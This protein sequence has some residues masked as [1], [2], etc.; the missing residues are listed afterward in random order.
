M[1]LMGTLCRKKHCTSQGC[2]CNANSNEPCMYGLEL[3]GANRLLRRILRLLRW[4]VRCVCIVHGQ[5]RSGPQETMN[6]QIRQRMAADRYG[7]LGGNERCS[8]M[9]RKSSAKLNVYSRMLKET[10]VIHEQKSIRIHGRGGQGVV[11]A[12]ELLAVAAFHDGEH[13]LAFPSFGSERMGA[14]VIAYCRISTSPI[15]THAPIGAPDVLIIQDATLLNSADTLLGLASDGFCFIN[16]LRSAGELAGD[17]RLPALPE[18]HLVSL[19]ATEIA[20]T[21]IGRAVPNVPLLGAYAVVCEDISIAALEHAIRDRFPPAIAEK[22][23]R[24]VEAGAEAAR[25]EVLNHAH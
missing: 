20:L 25:A 14:P 19:P 21:H 9:R 8:S 7:V 17:P 16:T 6:G 13:S 1:G 22:N 24:A 2:C 18:G 3:P 10:V 12:A 4:C 23:C 15:R 11:T 5:Y